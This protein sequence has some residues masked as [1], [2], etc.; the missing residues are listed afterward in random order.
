MPHYRIVEMICDWWTFS[1]KTGNL[2]EIFDWYK[3][4]EK[5]IVFSPKTRETVE[6]ILDGIAAKLD[7]MEEGDD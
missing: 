4:H 6:D 3:K 5:R 7:E 1:W 2:H